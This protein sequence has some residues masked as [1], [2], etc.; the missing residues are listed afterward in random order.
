M[1]L[2]GKKEVVEE[3]ETH[4]KPFK[5]R[6]AFRDGVI[7]EFVSVDEV[8]YDSD[9]VTE[10]SVLQMTVADGGKN[11]EVMVPYHNILYI[12]DEIVSD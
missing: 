9:L 8:L 12:M 10:T 5:V 11:Y 6:I 3:P 2:F 7:Q 4:V 1:S